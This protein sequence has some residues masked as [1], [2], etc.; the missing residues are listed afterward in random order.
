MRDIG[1]LPLLVFSPHLDDAVLS[2]RR[3]L[4]A[5]P[6]SIIATVC[7]ARPEG[8]AVLTDWDRDSGFTSSWGCM[9]ARLE[10]DARA[11]ALVGATQQLMGFLDGQ[12]GRRR[13]DDVTAAMARLIHS[14]LDSHVPG[15]PLGMIHPDHV[16]VADNFLDAPSVTGLESFI[17]YEEVPY[18]ASR[19]SNEVRAQR[20]SKLFERRWQPSLVEVLES[21]NRTT[22][23]ALACYASQLPLLD[24]AG[25]DATETWWHVTRCR[26][27]SGCGSAGTSDEVQVNCDGTRRS[28]PSRDERG[29]AIRSSAGASVTSAGPSGTA[30]ASARTP[31]SGRSAR[32]PTG[33][34][35]ADATTARRACTPLLRAGDAPNGDAAPRSSAGSGSPCAA[36]RRGRFAL[37]AVARTC[38]TMTPLRR[39]P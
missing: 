38:E 1:Q 2:A 4:A 23:A 12:Y 37:R 36:R 24:A 15:A 16:A 30:R 3:A 20:F 21:S 28:S 26:D 19:R 10:E 13:D 32:D 9:S 33:R 7:T 6:G 5:R 27:A 29:R 17:L 31:A 34:S 25:V 8:R 11:V 22:D 35:A 14:K 39:C 18:R